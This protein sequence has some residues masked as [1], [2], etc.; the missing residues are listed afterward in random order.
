[1]TQNRAIYQTMKHRQK[2]IK[3]KLRAI[4]PK[5]SIFKKRW[6]WVLVLLLL[7]AGTIFYMV[8][9]SS[10]LQIKNITISGNQKI[11]TE[12][13]KS[14]VSTDAN[15]TLFSKNILLVD[16]NKV[17]K[18]ILRAFPDIESVEVQKNW[19][20]DLEIK[21]KERKPFAALCGKDNSDNCFLIDENGVAFEMLPIVPEKMIILN[22]GSS[23]KITIGKTAIEKTTAGNIANISKNLKDNFQLDIKTVAADNPLIVTTTEGW[24][25]YFD[26]TQN[27]D[28]Q[29]TKMNLLLKNQITPAI[30]K[31]LQ[32][33]YLQYTDRAYYK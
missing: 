1:M 8:F 31:N 6:F 26:P 30:R 17:A 9:L 33:I 25:I 7:L 10:I 3:H 28:A 29:I 19:P 16:K 24:Q 32:Y 18:D 22:Q 20:Q 15:N 27:I 23:N 12:D 13:I 2:H 4:R 21:I 5:Q 11:K 14:I